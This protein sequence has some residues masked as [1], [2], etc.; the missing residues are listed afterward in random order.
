MEAERAGRAFATDA[1]AATSRPCYDSR[2]RVL[3][4]LAM[5]GGFCLLPLQIT[6]VNRMGGALR[7][8]GYRSVKTYLSRWRQLHMEA[9]M[10][11]DPATAAAFRGAMRA[12]VRG[13]GPARRAAALQLDVLARLS[14]SGSLRQQAGP[15]EFADFVRVGVWWLLREAEAAGLSVD[16]VLPG[17]AGSPIALRLGATKT[18]IQGRGVTRAHRCICDRSSM[19]AALPTLRPASPMA[20]A[21]A[22]ASR[23]RRTT[24]P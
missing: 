5:A 18:D 19:A 13:L 22:S 15:A 11:W 12:A 10:P 21:T 7:A 4:A 23:P 2:S 9:G 24:L 17:G 6:H 16:A 20:S 1:L 8:A 14:I 3:K